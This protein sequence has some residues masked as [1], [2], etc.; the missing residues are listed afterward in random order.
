LEGR[1]MKNSAVEDVYVIWLFVEFA[2]SL[3]ISVFEIFTCVNGTSLGFSN[4]WLLST[5]SECRVT[6]SRPR[7]LRTRY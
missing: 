6:I 1:S 4:S 5:G 3:A 2:E 7:I